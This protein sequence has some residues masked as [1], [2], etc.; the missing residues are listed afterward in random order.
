MVAGDSDQGFGNALGLLC[1]PPRLPPT[2]LGAF[3]QRGSQSPAQAKRSPCYEP[4][5]NIN[6]VNGG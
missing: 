6:F 3:E 2:E 4:W 1:R 5:E